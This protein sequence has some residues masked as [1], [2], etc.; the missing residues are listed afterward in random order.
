MTP[1]AVRHVL[2]RYERELSCS[3]CAAGAGQWVGHDCRLRYPTEAAGGPCIRGMRVWQTNQPGYV[4]VPKAQRDHVLG[5]LPKVR[6]F[7]DEGRVEKAMRWLGFVQGWLWAIGRYTVP[8]LADHNREA[9]ERFPA[10]QRTEPESGISFRFE[11]RGRYI[12]LSLHNGHVQVDVGHIHPPL[13][14]LHQAVLLDPDLAR[15]VA[16]HLEALADR[17]ER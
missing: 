16:T 6:A 4:E 2:D 12:E 1:A 7:L 8:E 10:P 5:M 15:F 11:A 17:L 3:A 14:K 9:S 13:L